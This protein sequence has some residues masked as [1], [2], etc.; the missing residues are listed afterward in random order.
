[1]PRPAPILQPEQVPLNGNVLGAIK[2]TWFIRVHAA[3]F[4]EPTDSLLLAFTLEQ[5]VRSRR[6]HKIGALPCWCTPRL[7]E[8]AGL[9][10]GLT[11]DLRK[12][13]RRNRRRRFFWTPAPGCRWAWYAA[14]LKTPRSHASLTLHNQ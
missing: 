5:G 6:D 2:G 13:A 4:L 12:Q 9:R 3:S 10:D 11:S 8:E 1:V 7:L 14:H